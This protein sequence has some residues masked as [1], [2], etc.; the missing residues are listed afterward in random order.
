VIASPGEIKPLELS[1]RAQPVSAAIARAAAHHGLSPALISAVAWQESH[2]RQDAVS[3]AGARGVMQ[4]MPATAR[5]LGVRTDELS[6]NVEGGT[7]YLARMLD[8][9]DGDIPKALAAYNAGPEA[10]DRYH[11]TPPYPETRSYVSAVL[12][13]LAEMGTTTQEGRP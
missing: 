10:V 9:Y 5:D 6:A 2:M 1:S 8:R 3:P 11:G 12:D 4:L 13:R 7:T